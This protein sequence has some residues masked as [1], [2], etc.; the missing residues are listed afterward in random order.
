MYYKIE[1]TLFWKNSC[2]QANNIFL[3]LNILL[4][5]VERFTEHNFHKKELFNDDVNCI[6]KEHRV[7]LICSNEKIF[8]INF[9]FEIVEG[10]ILF[11]G[12]IIDINIVKAIKRIMDILKNVNSY[13]EFLI[14]YDSIEDSED[15]K[16]N[17]IEL[18]SQILKKL[19]EVEIG[20]IRYDKDERASEKHGENY[21]PE[22]HLDIFFDDKLSCKIGIKKESFNFKR[23]IENIFNKLFDKT[24]SIEKLFIDLNE[25]K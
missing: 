5:I 21:H 18:A 13:E 6:I 11:E 24:N 7:F 17:E 25:T 9:P 16:I 12:E 23:D 10:G 2:K 22:N 20:Y 15:L 19:M 4:D 1:N 3:V 14:E 8:S